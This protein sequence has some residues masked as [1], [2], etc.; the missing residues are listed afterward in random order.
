MLVFRKILRQ[1]KCMILKHNFD[2]L[3]AFNSQYWKTEPPWV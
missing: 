2:I 1:T 3:R